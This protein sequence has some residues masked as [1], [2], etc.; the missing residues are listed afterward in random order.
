MSD[1]QVITKNPKLSPKEKTEPPP[2]YVL[3]LH[4]DPMT[5]LGFVV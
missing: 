2:I 3:I 4:N 5:P 1:S